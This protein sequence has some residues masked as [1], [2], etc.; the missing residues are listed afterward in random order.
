MDWITTTTLLHDLNDFNNEA[1]WER[2][3]ARFRRPVI[4]FARQLGV[5]E[6]D[7]EDI[8]QEALLVFVKAYREGRYARERGRLGSWL[9]G[10]A[11]HKVFEHRRRQVRAESLQA[12]AAEAPPPAPAE[13]AL[14]AQTWER[15]WERAF[16][17]ECMARVRREFSEEIYRA[18]ELVVVG[19]LTP[20]EAATALGVPVKR[21]YNA[22]HRVLTRIRRLRA[23]LEGEE[24]LPGSGAP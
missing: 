1:A 23:D 22:K 20:A 12:A 5:P 6:G 4:A 3:V 18:F 7:A 11:H 16:L 2:F 19:S 17:E 9:F 10:I 8:A 24:A 15:E 14:A 13:D 21:I